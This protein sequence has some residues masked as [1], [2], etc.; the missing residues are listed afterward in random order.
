MKNA[1]NILKIC[2]SRHMMGCISQPE[3]FKNEILKTVFIVTNLCDFYSE[4]QKCL[5]SY[6]QYRLN[7][8][9]DQLNCKLHFTLHFTH[10]TFMLKTLF[11]RFFFK[12]D[13]EMVHII[14]LQIIHTG[15]NYGQKLLRTS[16]QKCKV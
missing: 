2:S 1:Q 15:P 6:Y 11:I 12:F 13:L 5:C 10:Y 8:C 9:P 14:A 4:T 3:S 16:L 7:L